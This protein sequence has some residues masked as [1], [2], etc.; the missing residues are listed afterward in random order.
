M[1]KKSILIKEKIR[2]LNFSSFNYKL[3]YNLLL[4]LTKLKSI[5][6]NLFLKLKFQIQ[7]LN[8]KLSRQKKRCFKTGRSRSFISFF[9]LGRH[10]LKEFIAEKL[11]PGLRKSSW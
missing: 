4:N 6:F 7:K 5:D 1:I 8:I 3:K 10:S 9:G 2:E 11:L